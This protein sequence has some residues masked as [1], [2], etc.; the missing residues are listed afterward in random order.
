MLLEYQI[1]FKK[2]QTQSTL[3]SPQTVD[4]QDGRL[5]RHFQVNTT[6]SIRENTAQYSRTS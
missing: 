2:R 3:I 4:G 6:Q 5:E 1:K